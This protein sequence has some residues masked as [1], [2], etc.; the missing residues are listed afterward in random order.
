MLYSTICHNPDYDVFINEYV[1]STSISTTNMEFVIAEIT[2]YLI[3]PLNPTY[4]LANKVL[5][6]EFFMYSYEE[7]SIENVELLSTELRSL[8]IKIYS[9]LNN[10]AGKTLIDKTFD[11][12]LIKKLLHSTN[13][14][15]NKFVIDKDVLIV[16]WIKN[17][18]TYSLVLAKVLFDEDEL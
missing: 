17:K 1:T 8:R 4:N 11:D 16:G 18:G 15:I 9:S 13:E 10:D 7:P 5:L 12:N 3:L 2:D 6:E 14:L